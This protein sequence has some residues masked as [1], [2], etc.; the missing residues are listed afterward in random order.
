MSVEYEDIPLYSNLVNLIRERLAPPKVY[1]DWAWPTTGALMDC[2]TS[3][4]YKPSWFPTPSRHLAVPSDPVTVTEYERSFEDGRDLS[5]DDEPTDPEPVKESVLAYLKENVERMTQAEQAGFDA[6]CQTIRKTCSRPQAANEL[7][8]HDFR[9]GTANMDLWQD[10]WWHC[11]R[12]LQAIN[13]RQPIADG[14]Y[15]D[16]ELD[17]MM[18]LAMIRGGTDPIPWL[19]VLSGLIRRICSAYISP[20]KVFQDS[21][22][23]HVLTLLVEEFT[24]FAH[25][26]AITGLPL[27]FRFLTQGTSPPDN[28]IRWYSMICALDPR[29][30]KAD[31]LRALPSPVSIYL[32]SAKNRNDTT[33]GSERKLLVRGNFSVSTR[34]SRLGHPGVRSFISLN[35]SHGYGCLSSWFIWREPHPSL[36]A[37]AY[38]FTELH[39]VDGCKASR[40]KDDMNF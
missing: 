32:A 4:F 37:A 14:A 30:A 15:Q 27:R 9:L 18:V 23:G 25:A 2:Q 10:N 39:H 21:G 31:C 20:E 12:L 24:L 6:I 13:R 3:L 1:R 22:A 7:P 11:R 5:E 28:R 36:V 26:T 16:F 8:L 33:V 40:G 35:R 34:E 29:C 38:W 17:L 19:P